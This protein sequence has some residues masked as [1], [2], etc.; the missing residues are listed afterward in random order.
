ME[1]QDVNDYKPKH[2]GRSPAGEGS[3]CLDRVLT[4]LQRARTSGPARTDDTDSSTTRLGRAEELLPL[5]TALTSDVEARGSSAEWA[6]SDAV[7]AR[8][9]LDIYDRVVHELRAVA[10][11]SGRSMETAAATLAEAQRFA[12]QRQRRATRSAP[13][14]PGEQ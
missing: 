3:Q 8:L 7:L 4:A 6:K 5:L 14:T 9:L 13:N 1:P 11:N 2:G 10:T 12:R